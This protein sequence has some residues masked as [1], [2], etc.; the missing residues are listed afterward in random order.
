MLLHWSRECPVPKWNTRMIVWLIIITSHATSEHFNIN[1]KLKIWLSCCLQKLFT[2]HNK[3]SPSC[4]LASGQDGSWPFSIIT[5]SMTFSTRAGGLPYDLISPIS[6]LFKASKA[7]QIQTTKTGC[8]FCEI[9]QLYFASLKFK[10][11]SLAWSQVSKIWKHLMRN[12]SS[13]FLITVQTVTKVWK[14]GNLVLSLLKCPPGT[15]PPNSLAIKPTP[16]LHPL[17]YFSLHLNCYFI[18]WSAF[19]THSELTL[20]CQ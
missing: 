16:L 4:L 18:C 13:C 20:T 2:E 11:N 14:N 8:T 3:H 17:L 1:N 19:L 15:S 12:Y 7:C 10:I 6:F 9:L 5:A